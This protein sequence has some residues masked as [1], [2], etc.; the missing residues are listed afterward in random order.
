MTTKKQQTAATMDK[1]ESISG[2]PK[3]I[4]KAQKKKKDKEQIWDKD[5]MEIYF[6]SPFFIAH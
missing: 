2:K 1:S 6:R 3:K 5:M 4:K